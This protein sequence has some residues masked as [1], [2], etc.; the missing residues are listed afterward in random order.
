MGWE[1]GQPRVL[2]GTCVQQ[3]AQL[4]LTVERGHSRPL[5]PTA[6]DE[7][8]GGVCDRGVGGVIQDVVIGV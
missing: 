6:G 8:C 1:R 3:G 5:S 7:D 4:C 2:Q